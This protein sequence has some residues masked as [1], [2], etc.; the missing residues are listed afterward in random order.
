MT[1]QIE[2]D[3]RLMKHTLV[4]TSTDWQQWC[5]SLPPLKDVHYTLV[6]R[7][8]TIVCDSVDSKLVGEKLFD[9][10]EVNESFE[11]KFAS[12]L[13]KSPTFNTQAVFAS[14]RL[15]DDLMIRKVIPVSSLRDNMDRFDRVLFLRIVPFAFGSYLIFI[16]L[17]F[18]STRPLGVILSKVEKFKDDIPFN[19][20][21]ALLYERDE[22]R[23]IEEALNKADQRL[24]SHVLEVKSENEKSAAIL[25]A[26][27]DDIIAIDKFETVLFY[28][29]KFKKNFIHRETGKKIDLKIWHIFSDEIVLE[30]FRSVLKTAQP[31]SLKRMTFPGSNRTEKYYDLTITPLK[32]GHDSIT[33]ALGVFYDVTEFKLTEQMRV[34]FVA[35]V[36]HEIRTPLTSIKGFTQILQSQASKI[37]E[38]LHPFLDK[39]V[40]NTERMIS[41]FNDLLNLSVIESKNLQRLEE[42]SLEQM[43]EGITSINANYPDKEIIIDTHIEKDLFK[44]DPRLIEQVILNLT[45]NA[46]KYAD[47]KVKITISSYERNDKGYIIIEDNGPGIAE[48]HLPRIFERFY[49]T[50]FSRESS[51]GTGLGLAIVKNIVTKHKGKIWAESK[52]PGF[53]TRF[54]IEL[55]I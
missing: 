50:D 52:G 12:S 54:V 8:G 18:R 14:M 20:S 25:E 43:L 2:E 37:D 34:D 15:G 3:L 48:E 28:N 38:G 31:Y 17:F 23:R 10:L 9:L 49:R 40:F 1:L 32:A 45:D 29:N 7:N 6:R 19:K 4:R 33:G 42:F 51:R 36:S 22:W 41:L 47:E 24:Q 5:E 13:R 46:C 55:P 16:F 39:I 27:N 35:N 21:L 30:G 44:G 53:G 26:I 11:S